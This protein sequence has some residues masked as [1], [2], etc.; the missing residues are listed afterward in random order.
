MDHRA[1][2]LV[3]LSRDPQ[4]K[5][6]E[7]QSILLWPGFDAKSEKMR[8]AYLRNYLKKYY[9]SCVKGIVEGDEND[10][11]DAQRGLWLSTLLDDKELVA[12]LGGI[13]KIFEENFIDS[14][15]IEKAEKRSRIIGITKFIQ[16]CN[17]EDKSGRMKKFE[18][19]NSIYQGIGRGKLPSIFKYEAFTEDAAKGYAVACTA[20]AHLI[21]ADFA[22][23]E[24]I[25]QKI[26]PLSVDPVDRYNVTMLYAVHFYNWIFTKKKTTGSRK[27]N[28]SKKDVWGVPLDVN[29]LKVPT[30]LVELFVDAVSSHHYVP[31]EKIPDASPKKPVPVLDGRKTKITVRDLIK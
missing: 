9:I 29:G 15:A 24:I 11:E 5:L 20:G 8:K 2:K 30:E 12:Y 23:N 14:K 21:L 7:L 6:E 10:T 13:E 4:G 1:H 31:P 3:F 26:K 22:F 25:K 16:Y 28:F 19:L 27:D 17:C 18:S